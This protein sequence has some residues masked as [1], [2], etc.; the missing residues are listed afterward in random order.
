[1]AYTPR[2]LKELRLRSEELARN[3]STRVPIV[4]CVDT[5]YSM[6]IDGRIGQVNDGIRRFLADM[7]ADRPAMPAPITSTSVVCST[8]AFS[9]SAVSGAAL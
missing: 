7:A 1:M 4:L 6:S 8:A 5:S 9:T 3:P 2:P